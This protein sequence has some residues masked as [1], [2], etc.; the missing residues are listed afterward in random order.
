M[1][2]S[3]KV[4]SF[5]K[6]FSVWVIGSLVFLGMVLC[7]KYAGQ[8]NNGLELVNGIFFVLFIVAFIFYCIL[9]GKMVEKFDEEKEV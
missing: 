8:F 3:N 9:L 4:I 7:A 1:K 2:I 6:G 5:F